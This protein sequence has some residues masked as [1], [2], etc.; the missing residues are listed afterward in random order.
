MFEEILEGAHGDPQSLALHAA[1]PIG[2]HRGAA[3]EIIIR[4]GHTN[5]VVPLAQTERLIDDIRR[6]T[7]GR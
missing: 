1:P 3:G 2:V 6:E 5:I 4:Q 7:T